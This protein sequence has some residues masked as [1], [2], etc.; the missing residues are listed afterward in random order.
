[1]ITIYVSKGKQ[2]LTVIY[3]ANGGT[4]DVTK[5]TLYHGGIYGEL[6]T[7]TRTGYEFN[8]WYTEKTGGTK[9]TSDAI[10]TENQILY[11]QWTVKQSELTFD[12]NGGTVT[13]LPKNIDY[14]AVYGTLPVPTRDYYNF[15]G[16]YT[17]KSGGSQV[18]NST[19]M[20][21]EDVTIY[22]QWEQKPL[23][24]WVLSSK[25]PSSAKIVNTKWTYTRTQTTESTSSTKSGW[26]QTGTYWK[27]VGSDFIY[28]ASFPTGF[29]TSNSIYT[30]FS[31]S[32]YSEYE[33]VNIK[34]EVSNSWEGYVYWHWMYDVSYANSTTRAISNRSGW[35]DEYGNRGSGFNYKFFY[36]FTSKVNCSYLDNY[37]CCSQNLPSYYCH[38][39]LA[40][41]TNV[42][43]PRFF[44]FEYYK[45]TY[46]DYQKIYK[47]R[48][49]TTGIE[50]T[51]KVTAGGEISN[52]QEWV[53]YRE[54]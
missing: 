36:A 9:V 41:T 43:T 46:T 11:A 12:A 18:T 29:D 50:S 4:V 51:T 33:K 2:P 23:S 48:K 39:I 45:S 16:W 32:P 6:P 1:M 14:G 37:Y 44:R 21:T 20:G 25:V 47:Y 5:A 53:Q 52:V 8:G 38:N 24:S 3:D 7:P 28:Y 42:G 40:T 49:V 15:K 27:K 35:W 22:A 54:K 17:A 31:Q 30:S 13:A 10:V 19:K 34:R 26:T